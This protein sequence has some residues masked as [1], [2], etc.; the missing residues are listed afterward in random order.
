MASAEGYPRCSNRDSGRHVRNRKGFQANNIFARP[1]SNGLYA[2]W[3]YGE[4]YP[5][6]VHDPDAGWFH[7]TDRYSPTTSKHTSQ[8]GALLL[9]EG[10]TTAFL[11]DLLKRGGLVNMVDAR[12]TTEGAFA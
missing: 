11:C 9:G 10:K 2:V 5:L 3:S 4:H 12:I 6:A 1:M 7:N 8:T